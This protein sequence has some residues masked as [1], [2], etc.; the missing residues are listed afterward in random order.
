M[1]DFRPVPD[2]AHDPMPTPEQINALLGAQALHEFAPTIRAINAANG[3]AAGFTFDQTPIFLALVHSEVTEADDELEVRELDAYA[4]EL[5][6]VII[7]GLDLCELLLPGAVVGVDLA[8]FEIDAGMG[9]ARDYRLLLDLHRHA[10][11]ALQAYRKVQDEDEARRAVL[12]HLYGLIRLAHSM[13]LESERPVAEVL[14]GLL[15]NNRE[16]GQRHGGRRC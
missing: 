10:T 16:R 3:W 7:R 8:G 12:H 15:L 6:D 14:V 2:P 13:L 1:T 4:E 9:L 5:G 11:R